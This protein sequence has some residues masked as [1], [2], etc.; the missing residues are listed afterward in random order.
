ML[1][2]CYMYSCPAGG[3]MSIMV[4]VIGSE[5]L[6]FVWSRIPADVLVLT[7]ATVTVTTDSGT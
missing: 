4:P 5:R 2:I 3:S 1:L 6:Q 7:P